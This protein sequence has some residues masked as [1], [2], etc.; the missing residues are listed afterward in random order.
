M[1]GIRHCEQ[2]RPVPR[3]LVSADCPAKEAGSESKH[4]C[5]DG[6]SHGAASRGEGGECSVDALGAKKAPSRELIS[7]SVDKGYGRARS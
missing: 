4:A 1:S 5:L 2:A 6:V 3:T 7:Q